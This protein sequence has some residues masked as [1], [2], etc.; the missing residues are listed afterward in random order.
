MKVK[1][2]GIGNK[3]K[4][5]I[6]NLKEKDFQGINLTTVEKKSPESLLEK[7]DLDSYC[8]QYGKRLRIRKYLFYY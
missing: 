5:V 1:L 4:E 2:V 6:E 3:G 7:I 8:C